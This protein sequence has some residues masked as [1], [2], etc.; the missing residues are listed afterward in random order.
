MTTEERKAEAKKAKREAAYQ[1]R[2]KAKE[3]MDAKMCELVLH[4]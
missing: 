4:G 3:E 1:S 2:L